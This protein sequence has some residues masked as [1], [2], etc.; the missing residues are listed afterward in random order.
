M[1]SGNGGG[2]ERRQSH[3]AVRLVGELMAASE[4]VVWR[5]SRARKVPLCSRARKR[6]GS[7]TEWHLRLALALAARVGCLTHF[8]RVGPMQS[9]M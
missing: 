6:P 1:R 9:A 5:P 3:G 7:L 2:F 8:R 4:T